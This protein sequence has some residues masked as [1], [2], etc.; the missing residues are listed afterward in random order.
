MGTEGWVSKGTEGSY[1]F[2]ALPWSCTSCPRGPT[3]EE[4]GPTSTWAWAR[5]IS[6]SNSSCFHSSL[7]TQ[8]RAWTRPAGRNGEG[9]AWP[10]SSPFLT[11]EGSV[12][13]GFLGRNQA[14]SLIP[15]PGPSAGLE[16]GA[17]PDQRP[18]TFVKEEGSEERLGFPL[19]QGAST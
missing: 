15:F 13:A 10:F 4:P 2:W 16:R 12:A 14:P 19:R 11:A 3:E 5:P 7:G 6:Y 9:A 1:H 18:L 8:P 17:G